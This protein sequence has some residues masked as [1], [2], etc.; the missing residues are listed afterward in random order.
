MCRF[1][2]GRAG[3]GRLGQGRS[4]SSWA[5]LG[6]RKAVRHWAAARQPLPPRRAWGAAV[7]ATLGGHWVKAR[8][9]STTPQA[10]FGGRCPHAMDLAFSFACGVLEIPPQ[11]RLHAMDQA[12]SFTA[13]H[14]RYGTRHAMDLAFSFTATASLVSSL[15]RSIHRSK[16][17]QR[18]RGCPS[19]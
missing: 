15:S 7:K 2:S 11:G 1:A 3:E 10:I 16:Y 9:I 17:L 19:S 8:R 18:A 13:R 6:S 5:G 14:E 4:R 12:F